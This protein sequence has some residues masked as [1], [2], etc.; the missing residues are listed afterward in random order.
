VL[1]DRWGVPHIFARNEHDLFFAQGYVTAQ[2]RLWQMDLQR[3]T[4]SGRL[5]EVLGPATLETDLFL[6]T[7][8]LRRVA[9]AE[10]AQ[11]DAATLQVL[12]AYAAGV[13]AFVAAQ[14]DRLPLEFTILG[15]TP[16]PWTPADSLAWGK[17]LAWDL[18]GNWR[19]ELLNAALLARFGPEA[20]QELTPGYPGGGPVVVNPVSYRGVEELLALADRV[21]RW[22]GAAG[23]EIG[24]N[25]WVLAGARTTTGAPL[26][27]NDPHLGIQMPS[28]WYEVHLNAPGWDVAG[29]SLVGVP[30]VVIGHNR[31]I[32]W[33]VTNAGPDVQDLYLEQVNPEN[34]RQYRYQDRWEEFQVIR[35]EIG[36]RGRARP[37]QLDVY[38]SRHGPLINGVVK[39]LERPMALRWTALE[40]NGVYRALIALNR[41]GSWEEFRAALHDFAVPA[42]NFV[43]ADVDGN[44]GYQLPGRIPVRALGE[45]QYPVP[46]WTGEY[47][48]KGYIPFDELPSLFNPPAGY[49]VTANNKVVDDG[50]RYF[51]TRD[52]APPFR[53]QRIIELLNAKRQLSVE[54]LARVQ[55]D[56]RSEPS[57][58]FAQYLL[59][60]R[61][62][63]E[64]SRRALGVLS[65]WDGTLAASSAAGALVEVWYAK[66]LQNA[67]ADEMGRDL[68]ERFRAGPHVPAVLGLLER[69]GGY[70][71]NVVRGPA[72][73]DLEATALLSLKQAVEEL[74]IQFGPDPAGWR[75]GK[76]H[77]ATFTHALGRVQPL[78]L[79]FNLGPIERG[80][81]GF[82]VNNAG[83][84]YNAPFAQATV[85][86]LRL[87]ADAGDWN[88]SRLVITTGQSG[89]PFSPHFRDQLDLWAAGETHPMPFDRAQI[90]RFL[91][92]R[93]VLEP[94]GEAR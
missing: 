67:F 19:R 9:A 11:L 27:A 41:A 94:A 10:V 65:N 78:N 56:E 51:I 74:S 54:D 92:A 14:R 93:L 71:F 20:W 36:V 45:G 85:A 48:W 90:E 77:Q 89:Q 80:G 21:D 58:R 40:P 55:A 52:W 83:Y 34:P 32:A 88:R 5:S 35:E 6:R 8:G 49:V 47:E 1:R 69:K 86:S 17:V 68:F 72:R 26:L 63:D 22:L 46:G 76:L 60:L 79:L 3:R 16:E 44:I 38:L 37:E 28:V 25:N 70:W 57:Y 66:F 4:A 82:T 50:Y 33:G 24:S 84:S 18:G 87:I 42:Q 81:N 59:S 39:G 61:P 30:G 64:P 73:P 23:P 53:A 7:L 31:R 29:A 43:Y 2:D 62:A 91:A 13:N 15:F 12:E 75:W